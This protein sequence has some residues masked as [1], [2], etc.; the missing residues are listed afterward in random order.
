MSA[1]VVMPSSSLLKWIPAVE[2]LRTYTFADAR[3]DVVAGITVATVAVPQAMAYAL[4]AGV[5]PEYGLYTA[6]VMT[7]VGAVFDSSRQLING[8]TNAISIAVLSALAGIEGTD[9]RIAAAVTLALLVGSL[10]VGITLLRLGDLTRYVSHSVIIGF[11]VGASALL[12]L[13]Q[14]KNLLGLKAMGDAHDHFLVRFWLTMTEGG[15]VHHQTLAIGLATIGLVVLLRLVKHR[16][17]W[18]LFPDLFATVVIMAG[19]VGWLGLDQAGVR[20][21]GEIPPRLPSFHPPVIDTELARDLAPS[22]FAIAVLGLLEAIAMAKAIA[23]R[24]GQKLDMNQQCLSEGLANVAGSLFH[25]IPG[26]GSLTRSAINQQAGGRTQWSGVISAIAVA[27]IVLLFAPYA[28]YI[29]RAALAGILFVAS[30]RMI[31]WHAL[32]YHLRASRFDAGI[33]LATAAAA[34]FISIEFCVIIGILLSFMLAVPRAGRMLMTEF[35][36]TPERVIHERMG[37]ETVDPRILLFGFE[38][39]FFFGSAVAFENHLEHI[40]SRLQPETRYV[41]LRLKRVRNPDAVCVTLLDAFVGRMEDRGVHVLMCGVRGEL[42]D[43]LE[44]IGILE[45]FP[46]RVFVEQPVRNTSTLMAIKAAY[47]GLGGEARSEGMYYMI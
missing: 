20:V 41:V 46:E 17:G 35:V 24:T 23:A 40:E 19:V 10:Q 39:E 16:I 45:R 44:R 3:A 7:A 22:A 32:R 18:T 26:S 36:L 38:G 8:P 34:V 1:R 47:D 30:Y 11:T 27:A 6:I 21:V 12:A 25:C 33:V 4:L 37:D 43:A 5:P 42:H 9:A 14:L 13:D 28:R 2:A 31:D 29:P 15:S